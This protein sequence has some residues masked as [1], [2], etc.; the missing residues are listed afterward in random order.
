ME[1]HCI[2]CQIVEGKEEAF[3]VD[4]DQLTIAFLDKNPISSGHTLI[5]PKNH[6]KNIFDIPKDVLERILAVS[7]RLAKKYTEKLQATGFNLV[8]SNGKDAQQSVFHF[9]FHLVP[10]YPGDNLDLWFHGRN[11]GEDL[12]EIFQTIKS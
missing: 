4:E 12:E 11:K 2:F 8:N 3:I 1:K 6:Y 10:R 5:I 9:H 7:R